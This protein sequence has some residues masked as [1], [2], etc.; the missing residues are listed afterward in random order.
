MTVAKGQQGVQG[1][2][3]GAVTTE[4]GAML[5]LARNKKLSVDARGIGNKLVSSALTS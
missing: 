1:T 3:S 2:R 5:S 4:T